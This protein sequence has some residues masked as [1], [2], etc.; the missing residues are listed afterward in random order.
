M[1]SAAPQT[2]LEI[3]TQ[4][5][6]SQNAKDKCPMISLVS[7]IKK[8][9]KMNISPQ[10]KPISDSEDKLWLTKWKGVRNG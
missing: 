8:L 4:L 3:I 6:M 7:V 5:E 1:P 10:R 2:N 9:I